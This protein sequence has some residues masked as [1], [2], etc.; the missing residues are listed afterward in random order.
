MSSRPPAARPRVHVRVTRHGRELKIGGTL[1][2][3]YRRGDAM[4]GALWDGLAAP[5]A[6][7]APARVRRV[8]ILGLG[9]GSAARAIR[10]LA[11]AAEVVGVDSDRE[12]IA[13]AR[14][15]LAL[16]S[17]G[18]EIVHQDARRF[19]ETDR[20]RYD[21]VLEDVFVASK[22][23]AW[24]PDWLPL[25]GLAL[26]ARRLHAGGVLVSN[27][28]DET[29]PFVRAYRALFGRALTLRLRDYENGIVVGGVEIPA[30]ALRA[31]IAAR[32]LLRPVLP[33]LS[34]RAA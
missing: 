12:V 6:A 8:L 19:L 21:L 18:L 29:A 15:W 31:R 30:R 24:K 10:A 33:L 17:L 1:A 25:P 14:R 23:Q 22:G 5:L 16:D 34:I 7:L 13:A 4:T 11:P 2:S 26:A 20:R 28:I 9:G 27:T 32:P 3:Y